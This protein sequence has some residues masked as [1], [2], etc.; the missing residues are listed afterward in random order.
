MQCVCCVSV[1]M[2]CSL[3]LFLLRSRKETHPRLTWVLTF[4]RYQV[5][6]SLSP[7]HSKTTFRHNILIQY[8]ASST[9]SDGIVQDSGQANH[10]RHCSSNSNSIA[11]LLGNVG[12]IW[13]YKIQ[14]FVFIFHLR[15]K[16]Q[17]DLNFTREACID[18]SCIS[19]R[20]RNL[21]QIFK[22]H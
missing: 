10:R 4:A 14:L 2:S 9:N 3:S 19:F 7:P 15:N 13:I 21:E 16:L 20:V 22:L 1:M 11:E 5:F 18:N 12:Q 8:R 17:V 6:T